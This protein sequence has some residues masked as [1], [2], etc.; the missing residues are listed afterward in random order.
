MKISR[1]ST[2]LAPRWPESQ[3]EPLDDHVIRLLAKAPMSKREISAALGQ[4]EVSGRLNK[5][6]QGLVAAGRIQPS[7]PSKPTSRLQRYRLK[8]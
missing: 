4:Q 3:P 8:F 1:H 5:V 6:I 2:F 7:V